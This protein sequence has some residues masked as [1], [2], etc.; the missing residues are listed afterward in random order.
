LSQ[1]VLGILEEKAMDNF[2]SLSANRLLFDLAAR[3]GSLEGYL[4]AEAKVEKSY[5]PNWLQ[6][7]ERE[8]D[9]LPAQLQNEIRPDYLEVLKKVQ[10]LLRKLYGD[11]DANTQKITAIIS[12]PTK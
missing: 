3:L 7:V 12:S 9:C 8:F 4:Y 1:A 5:L 2:Q 6:N 11:S 10:A